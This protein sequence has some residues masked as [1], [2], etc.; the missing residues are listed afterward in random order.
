MYNQ[1]LNNKEGLRKFGIKQCKF[2]AI[3]YDSRAFK[4]G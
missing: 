2:K 1:L 4:T 3:W